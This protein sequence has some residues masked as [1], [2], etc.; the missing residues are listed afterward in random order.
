MLFWAAKPVLI[1]YKSS[2]ELSPWHCIQ[3]ATVEKTFQ[4]KPPRCL[5]RAKVELSTSLIC[6]FL[7]CLSARCKPD[8]SSNI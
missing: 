6:V 7:C 5:K 8:H 4:A 1:M 2:V 3:G